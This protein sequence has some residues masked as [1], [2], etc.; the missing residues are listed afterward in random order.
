MNPDNDQTHP[1]FSKTPV[2]SNHR[3]TLR[4]L[5]LSE[6][7]AIIDISVYNGVFAANATEAAHILEQINADIAK[8]ES[9]HWGIFLNETNEIAGTCGYYRGF[10]ENSGEI[11]YILK[12]SHRG[13]GLM[14]EA[15]QLLVD[16][17]FKTLKLDKIIAYTDPSN[18]ASVAVLQRVGFIE[19]QS[20]D[21]DRKFILPG[22][23][24]N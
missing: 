21:G 3:I 10:A 15:V 14:T 11:G 22:K 16:F 19:V 13:K 24:L 18:S 9:L 2:L 6:S 8:G 12:D 23:G 4:G 5:E 17:G 7:A 1:A 20:T